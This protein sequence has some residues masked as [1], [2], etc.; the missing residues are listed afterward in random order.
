MK[1]VIEA[2]KLLAEQTE[3]EDAKDS[4]NHSACGP[5]ACGGDYCGDIC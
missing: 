3:T 4:E 1:P 5:A 2:L